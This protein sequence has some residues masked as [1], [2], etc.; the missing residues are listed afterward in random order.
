M[1]WRVVVR[2]EAG[3][4][5]TEA[6]DWYDERSPGL[7]DQFIDEVLKVL[8]ALAENPLLNSRRH[9]RK[10]IRWRYPER[11][12]YR[13]IY[14]VLEEHQTVLVAAVLHAARHDREWKKRV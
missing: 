3:D 7:G 12:P 5:V 8:D 6:A 13:V 2:T 10:D 9:P 11:F 14:Q 4:D 1:S